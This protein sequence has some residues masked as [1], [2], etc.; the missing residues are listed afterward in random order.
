MTLL[1]CVVA[2]VINLGALSAPVVVIPPWAMRLE[3]RAVPRP[4]DLLLVVFLMAVSMRMNEQGTRHAI[5]T[6]IIN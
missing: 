3:V 5:L 1:K 6:R 2:C 4:T